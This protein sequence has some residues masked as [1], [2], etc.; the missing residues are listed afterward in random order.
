MRK[1]SMEE[2]KEIQLEILNAID[3]FCRENGINYWLDAGTLL[4]AVRHKGYIP[5]DDDIDIGMLR[6]DYDKFRESF[7]LNHDRYRFVCIESDKEFYCPYGKVMDLHTYMKDGHADSHINVD[8]FVCDNAPE[9]DRKVD[10]LFKR[11]DLLRKLYYRQVLEVNKNRNI[12][13]RT[14]D[15]LIK[16]VLNCLPKG[17]FLKKIAENAQKYTDGKDSRAANF[18]SIDRPIGPKSI[19]EEYIEVEFEGKVYKAPKGYDEWLKILYGDYMKL[20]PIEQRVTHHIIDA[21]VKE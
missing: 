17:Y 14:I 8:V 18:M 3:A 20:P 10:A 9:D 1:V 11:R 4:G 2:L 21:Y 5:W 16:V 19:W 12:I 7:N 15:Q 13:K 6:K